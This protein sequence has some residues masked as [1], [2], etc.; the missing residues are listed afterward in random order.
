[1]RL[2]STRFSSLF[3]S[4]TDLSEN[5]IPQDSI[6]MTAFP[7][8]PWHQVFQKQPFQYNPLWPAVIN[9][10]GGLNI[11]HLISFRGLSPFY[12]TKIAIEIG[13]IYIYT[14][15]WWF[16]PLSKWVITLVINGISGVSPLITRVITHLL[17]GMSRQVCSMY[18][19]FT[20]IYPKNHPVL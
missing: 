18:G 3:G 19:I 20:N 4:R 5:R 2:C 11:V 9:W 1:M 15:T 17:S 10:P 13:G 8:F 6:H 12:I 14:H 16:I 7:Q